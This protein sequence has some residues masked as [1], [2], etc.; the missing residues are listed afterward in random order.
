MKKFLLLLSF[1]LLLSSTIQAATW[2]VT[3]AW[4]PNPPVQQVIGYKLSVDN[5]VITNYTCNATICS[6]T[7][8]VTGNNNSNHTALATSINPW[9]ESKAATLKFTCK[10]SGGCK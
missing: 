9:G 7:T 1:I 3:L 6:A 8:T 10:N 2:T 4:D 5:K